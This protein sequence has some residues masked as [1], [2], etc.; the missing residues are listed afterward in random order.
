MAKGETI[1]LTSELSIR[2]SF[3]FPIQSSAS[4]REVLV[5]A[6]WLLVPVVGWLMN[7]GHRIRFV[8][9]MQHGRPAWP[10]WN[11]PWDLMKH[12]GPERTGLSPVDFWNQPRLNTPWSPMDRRGRQKPRQNRLRRFLVESQVLLWFPRSRCCIT[13]S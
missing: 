12:G 1:D 3:R 11:D 2:N 9:N 13:V 7:M 8:H 6:A 5:G 10:A 4:R